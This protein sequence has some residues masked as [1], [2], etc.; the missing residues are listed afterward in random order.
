MDGLFYKDIWWPC[1]IK[2]LGFSYDFPRVFRT[3][4]I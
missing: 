4:Y 3:V 1:L 2:Y